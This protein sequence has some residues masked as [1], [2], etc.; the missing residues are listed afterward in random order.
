MYTVLLVDDEQS[1]LNSL[2]NTIT[3]EE[4]GVSQI[5]TACNGYQALD[6]LNANHVDLIITDICMPGCDGLE[7]LATTRAAYPDVHC[8]VLTAYQEFEYAREALRLGAEDYLLKPF[9]QEELE[10]SIE[11]VFCNIYEKAEITDQIFQNNL[12]SRWVTNSIGIEELSERA[13]MLNINLFF[14]SYCAVCIQ[15]RNRSLTSTNLFTQVEKGARNNLAVYSF[16]DDKGR[17]CFILGG[18]GLSLD[19]VYQHL[20]STLHYTADDLCI[21]VGTIVNSS[22]QVYNSYHVA[23]STLETTNFA[24]ISSPILPP[25]N[26]PSVSANLL[27]SELSRLFSIKDINQRESSFKHFIQQLLQ[28]NQDRSILLKDLVHGLIQLFVQEF[29][30]KTGIQKQ[31]YGHIRLFQQIPDSE[32]F[33]TALFELLQYS[34]LLYQDYFNQITPVVQ[35][36][37]SYIRNH[38]AE[39]VSVK[40]FCSKNKMN[41]CYLGYLFK[42]ETGMFFSAYLTQCRICCALQLLL[43]T[44]YKL[45][46]IA[47][48][49]G[50]SSSS[51]LISCFKKQFGLSPI[52]YR[53]L[54]SSDIK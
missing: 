16:Y 47:Q 18:N 20:K 46:K 48:L 12:L 49:S 30:K 32:Q 5:L 31:I 14:S 1:I 23:C 9:V 40:E 41:T 54:I 43:E 53:N 39:S 15:I 19:D 35:K 21:S 28:T 45:P 11:K 38:Y 37:I 17:C 10:S 2:T 22:E 42:Q 27:S 52:Q 33:D 25:K 50:F 36:A 26:M 24:D 6:L 7:L 13:R 44:D 51:Y 8:I 29:P 3:W 4:L 34:F